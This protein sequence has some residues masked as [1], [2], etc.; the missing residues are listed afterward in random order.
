MMQYQ[1][2][3]VEDLLLHMWT[4]ILLI[5]QS[6]YHNLGIRSWMMKLL[7][8]WV[9]LSQIIRY[10][11]LSSL[12]SLLSICFT[13][14]GRTRSRRKYSRLYPLVDLPRISTS[15]GIDSKG[16]NQLTRC[17]SWC[18]TLWSML[19]NG[20]TCAQGLKT[21]SFQVTDFIFFQ[22]TKD[23]DKLMLA[24]GGENWGC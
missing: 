14:F 9:M 12:F 13:I 4:F 17:L 19:I 15:F 1:D 21:L 11:T 3:Q 22:S 24:S 16:G 18:V 8:S 20:E 23:T 10:V 5:K 2:H 7:V 6:L